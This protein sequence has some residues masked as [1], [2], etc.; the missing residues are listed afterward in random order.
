MTT[1]EKTVSILAEYKGIDASSI[2]PESTFQEIDLDSLDVAEL[3]MNL[4]DEFGV[5][6]ELSDGVTCVG[7]LVACIDGAAQ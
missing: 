2:K 1:L 5:T 7:D 3:V 6:I 4:E